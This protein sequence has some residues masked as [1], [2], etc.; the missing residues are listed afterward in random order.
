MGKRERV[1]E[2]LNQALHYLFAHDPHLFFLG[3]DILDPYGGAFKVSKGL[4]TSYGERILGTP[5][6]EGAI[7]GIANGLALCGQK[8]IVE[9]MFGDFITLAY[10]QIV[11]F[12]AKSVTMYGQ[13]VGLPIVVRCPVGGNRAYG[14]THSQHMLKHFL[15]IP[16]LSLFEL[17]PFHE[18][19]QLLN[20]ML[21][22]GNPCILFEDKILYTQ[23]MYQEGQIDDLFTFAFADAE[24]TIAQVTI[25]GGSPEDLML[26]APGGLVQRS[27]K[28][29]RKLLIEHEIGCRLFVPSQLYPI[30]LTPLLAM[31]AGAKHIFILEESVSG[32]NWGNEVARHLYQHLWGTLQRPVHLIHS[33]DSIIPAAPH[34]EKQVLLQDE[35]IYRSLCEVIYA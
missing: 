21:E 8:V 9:I 32:A 14:P 35:D 28:A 23:Y 4:S 29:M 6:S 2:N 3:E 12:A 19:A 1:V 20:S 24:R 15:G 33:R 10:D 16:N 17:S 22:L 18:N 26:I 7:M 11:N 13:R 27:L 30:A 34:L 5:L 25:E 31:L